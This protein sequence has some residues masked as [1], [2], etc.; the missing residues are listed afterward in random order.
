M[1]NSTRFFTFSIAILLLGISG[2]THATES[3]SENLQYNRDIRPILSHACFTCHGPDATARKAEL[4][5]D[6]RADA[7]RETESGALPIVPGKATASE[8]IQRI[9]TADLSQ[10]MPPEGHAALTAE[11]IETLTRWINQGAATLG[12]YHSH[13]CQNPNR[14]KQI[15][16]SQ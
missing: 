1:N 10:R 8:L 15:V 4:R 16:D 5:L 14:Q 13:Q 12:I 9:S 3:P 2:S 7:L 6:V 11:Q